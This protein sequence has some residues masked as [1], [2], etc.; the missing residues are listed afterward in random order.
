MR[1]LYERCSAG[2]NQR[3]KTTAN[4]LRKALYRVYI[5]KDIEAIY[6]KPWAESLGKV[7]EAHSEAAKRRRAAE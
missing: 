2:A 4:Y 3:E 5:W 7:V 6:G 1:L